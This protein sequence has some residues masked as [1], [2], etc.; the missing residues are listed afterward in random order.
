M[1]V[2]NIRLPHAH[3]AHAGLDRQIAR[4]MEDRDAAALRNSLHAV[5]AAGLLR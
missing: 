4:D 1:Q 2:Y 5:F 3:E